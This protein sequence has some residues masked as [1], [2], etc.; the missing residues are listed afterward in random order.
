MKGLII[1]ATCYGSTE[2]YADWI[3]HFTINEVK[4]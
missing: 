1:Y 2:Q 3:K 4:G